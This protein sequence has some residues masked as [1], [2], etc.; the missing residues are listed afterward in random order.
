MALSITHYSRTIDALFTHNKRT[1]PSLSL[2]H[3][4]RNSLLIHH[5]SLIVH[6]LF[7]SVQNPCNCHIISTCLHKNMYI[8]TIHLLTSNIFTTFAD[9]IQINTAY[10]ATCSSRYIPASQPILGF[11][12][13]LHALPRSA[14]HYRHRR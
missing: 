6:H 10:Y 4:D 1:I 2:Y 14:Y 5:L 8:S 12:R 3:K 11:L 13:L 9:E 7:S